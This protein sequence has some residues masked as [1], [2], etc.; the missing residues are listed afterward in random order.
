MPFY[1]LQNSFA[2]GEVSPA[3]YGRTDMAKYAISLRVMYNSYAHLHGGASNR[4]GIE[5]IAKAKHSG[6]KKCRVVGFEFST[7]Q[8]YMLEFGDQYI[9]FFKDG[10]QIATE[11]EAPYEIGSSYPAELLNELSFTQSADTLFIFHEQVPP[12]M[13]TRAG[14]TAWTLT[15]FEFRGGP[16]L[17]ANVTDTTITPS[18]ISGTVTLAA[19]A[20]VF[21]P[22]HVGALWRIRHF[23]EAKRMW[24]VPNPAAWV[25]GGEYRQN[26]CVA[27]GG[28]AYFCLSDVTSGT[29]PASDTTHWEQCSDNTAFEITV[30][31]SWTFVTAGWWKGKLFLQQYSDGV[32]KTIRNLTGTENKNYNESGTVEE[33]TRFRVVGDNF[34][35]TDTGEAYDRGYFVFD[36][37][38]GEHDGWGS[39][40]AYTDARHVQLLVKK[41]IGKAEATTDWAEGAWSKVRGYPSCAVFTHDD[42][43]MFAGTQ[44]GP[45]T[46]WMSQTSDYSNLSTSLP[47]TLDTDA[48][49]RTLVSRQVNQIRHLLAMSEIL[50]LTSGSEWKIGPGPNGTA[51]TPT[52]VETRIQGYRGSSQ[53]APVIIGNRVL[54]IQ[55]MGSTIRD[56]GYALDVDS[57][58]GNDLSVLARHLFAGHKIVSMAYQQEPDSIVWGV[59]DDGV[60]LSLT[61]L[62]DQD[63]WAWGRHETDGLFEWVDSI[64]GKDRTEI[65]FV[66]QRTINGQAERYIER[67]AARSQ[68]TDPKDKFFVDSGLTYEGDPATVISGFDHL[69]GKTV[70][71]LADGNVMPQQV[72]VDGKITLPNESRIVHGGLPYLSEIETLNA[73]FPARDGTIQGRKKRMPK[74]TLRVEN[75]RGAWVGPRRDKMREFKWRSTENYD[76]PTRLFTG[77]KELE[78]YSEP[79]REARLVIQQ[80]DPLPLTVLAIMAVVEFEDG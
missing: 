26:N 67:L 72:V 68:S 25:S 9:R 8:A 20:D 24:G 71:I 3:M 38:A 11:D 78:I 66:V 7:L 12:A 34:Q 39:I 23:L 54:Y 47:E 43:M 51:F 61:Y 37:A 35:P 28:K 27:Y 2:G 80:R 69:E 65:W 19:S 31:R 50:A 5:F 22:E 42:R 46:Y 30:Y 44:Y 40:T 32:W 10:G 70:A 41:D 45:N 73:D 56:L 57:Y 33:P 13:L 6:A 77:D 16:W 17:K 29:P 36:S 53:T 59:R 49:T 14:H 48:I 55:D 60:L 75:S 18:G 52:S 64:P 79:T 63:V 62:R 76:E 74:V 15:D 1:P 58:T 4:P 21:Q